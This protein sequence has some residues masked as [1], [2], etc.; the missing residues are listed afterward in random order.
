MDIVPSQVDSF[1]ILTLYPTHLRLEHRIP[2]NSRLKLIDRDE[3]QRLV[4]LRVDIFDLTL[5]RPTER[6]LPQIA[7]PRLV[8]TL[9]SA[10][11]QS[12][13][14]DDLSGTDLIE[15]L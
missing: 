13:I 8:K 12:H 11:D 5:D 9:N 3:Q 1:P 2:S 15:C 6:F 4:A 7:I 10:A 14:L